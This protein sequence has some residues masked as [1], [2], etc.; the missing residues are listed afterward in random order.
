MKVAT[1][2]APHDFQLSVDG[3]NQVC[4]G[5]VFSYGLGILEES[6]V[7]FSFLSQLGNP[8]GIDLGE[9]IA[10]LFELMIRGF[11]VPAGFDRSP[12]L[13]KLEGIGLGKMGSGVALH[14]DGAELD[15]RRRKK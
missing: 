8:G 4:A 13:L 15:I 9:T 12:S 7:V 2:V 10:E 3:F 1:A 14:M 6:E 11:A 5:E